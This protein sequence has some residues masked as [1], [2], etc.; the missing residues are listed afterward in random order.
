M[1][2][3]ISHMKHTYR[4]MYAIFYRNADATSLFLCSSSNSA[5]Y[6]R[7]LQ[8]KILT[9]EISLSQTN[10]YHKNHIALCLAPWPCSVCRWK[11]VYKGWLGKVKRYPTFDGRRNA[12]DYIS[13]KVSSSATRV[14]SF[15]VV[16]NSCGSDTPH[17][18]D[19]P[20]PSG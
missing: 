20:E 4:I 7:T 14:Y 10:E 16:K 8:D 12:R 5:W 11:R 2:V 13:L 18:E 6:R 9:S 1:Y 19:P 15:S 17:H 3:C